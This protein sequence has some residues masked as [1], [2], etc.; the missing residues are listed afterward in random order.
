MENIRILFKNI[1][2]LYNMKDVIIIFYGLIRTAYS[3]IDNINQNII[4]YNIQR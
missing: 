4:N 2:Y 1:Y 3:C